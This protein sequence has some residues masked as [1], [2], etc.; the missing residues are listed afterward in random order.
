M[1]RRGLDER[2]RKGRVSV[3][4]SSVEH[5]GA[6]VGGMSIIFSATL[7]IHVA[8]LVTISLVKQ[9]VSFTAD[10]SENPLSYPPLAPQ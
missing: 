9:G 5:A 4:T 6:E 8:T 2:T 3:D 1:E 7:S 10:W